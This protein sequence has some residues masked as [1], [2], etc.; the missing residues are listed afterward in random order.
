MLG[1]SEHDVDREEIQKRGKR[2][3]VPR[4]ERRTNPTR[5]AK[6]KADPMAGSSSS[7]PKAKKA[8]KAVARQAVSKKNNLQYTAE[9]PV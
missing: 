4:A 7:N 6:R 2:H 5:A 1:S 9:A 8:R 3:V